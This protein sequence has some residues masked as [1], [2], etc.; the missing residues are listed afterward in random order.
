MWQLA[1]VS[2]RYYSSKLGVGGLVRAYAG[3][4]GVGVITDQAF[5]LMAEFALTID[6]ARCLWEHLLGLHQGQVLQQDYGLSAVE[7]RVAAN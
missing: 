4:T 3:K 5:V 2:I 6:Y 1:A 7:I